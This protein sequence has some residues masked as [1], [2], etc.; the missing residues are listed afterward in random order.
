M[1]FKRG[2]GVAKIKLFSGMDFSGKST[3]I[4]CINTYIPNTF[5]CQE[6]FLTPIDTLEKMIAN[7]I[8][9]PPREEFVPLLL[10]LLEKDT[11]SYIEQG[12]I[13]QDTLWAIKFVARLCV[14]K[15]NYYQKE[16]DEIMNLI[17]R[18]PYVDS[19]YITTT[20]D[21]RIERYMIRK[22]LGKRISKSDIL[23]FSSDLFTEVENKYREIVFE[24]FPDTK[25]IDTTHNS[26]EIIVQ[27]LFKDNKFL[28]DL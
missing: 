23:I 28:S 27:D 13:L 3:I 9:L 12:T 20:I 6:K 11:S 10:D 21:K 24:L 1:V 22:N 8:W 19:F 15:D 26:P 17:I 25:L 5:I 4:K 14:D 2:M 7:N 18:Y 16:I